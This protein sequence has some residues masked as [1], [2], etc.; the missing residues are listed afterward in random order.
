VKIIDFGTALLLSKNEKDPTLPA[1]HLPLQWRGGYP[2][3][4][5]P[6][7]LAALLSIEG[8]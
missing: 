7:L 8:V 3:Y 1:L 6:Q 5:S 4:A 2:A